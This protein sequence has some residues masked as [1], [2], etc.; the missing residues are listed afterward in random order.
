MKKIYKNPQM[1]I[2]QLASVQLLAGSVMDVNG[3]YG[4]GSGITTGAPEFD[5]DFEEGLF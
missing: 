5:F 3:N 2:V 4:N 1:E